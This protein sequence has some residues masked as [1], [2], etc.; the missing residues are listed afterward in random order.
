MKMEIDKKNARLEFPAFPVV[1][2]T[3]EENIIAIGLVHIFSFTPL[4][5]GIGMHPQRH[6]YGLLE[7]IKDF[8]V[9]IP[10]K[11]LVEK[12]DLCGTLSGRDV[13]KFK[14]SGLTKMKPKKIKSVLIKECP[15]NLECDKVQKITFSGSHDWFVG[16]VVAAHRDEAYDREKALSYW[17]KEYRVMGERVLKR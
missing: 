17:D 16:E 10:T 13:D 14:E 5:I 4:K 3:V 15:V 8:G 6:S 2:V 11:E 7:K 1:L 9:N 12:V